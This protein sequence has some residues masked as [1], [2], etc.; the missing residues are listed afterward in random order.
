MCEKQII[1][2]RIELSETTKDTIMFIS[3]MGFLCVLAIVLL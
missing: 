2:H 3:L 1:I